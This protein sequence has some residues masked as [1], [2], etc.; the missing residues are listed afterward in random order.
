MTQVL[1]LPTCA[2][3]G[4]RAPCAAAAPRLLLLSPPPSLA[5]DAL[6]R[7]L[8]GVLYPWGDAAAWKWHLASMTT[9]LRRQSGP[10]EGSRPEPRAVQKR[11]EATCAA[12][13][14]APSR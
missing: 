4:A 11:Q 6:E 5:V 1:S 14:I 8:A 13:G 12:R 2:S 3:A 9:A 7:S 10:P